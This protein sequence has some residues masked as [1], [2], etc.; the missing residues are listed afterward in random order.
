MKEKLLKGIEDFN[1][2]KKILAKHNPMLGLIFIV[3]QKE[4]WCR[5]WK[6]IKVH[7]HDGD[8]HDS[9][10]I[11]KTNKDSRWRKLETIILNPRLWKLVFNHKQTK[12][13]VGLRVYKKEH[14]Q[15]KGFCSKTLFTCGG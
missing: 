7:H 14:K 1:L 15:T 2:K 11:E 4:E 10:V 9:L 6:L 13:F 3:K 12:G 8:D 5:L